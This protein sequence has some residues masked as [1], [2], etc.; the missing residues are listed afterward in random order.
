MTFSYS[1][2]EIN[3]ASKFIFE[4]INSKII[5]F[6]GDLGT[7]KTT[8]IKNLCLKLGSTENVSSPTFPILNIYEDKK[9]KIYHADLY[10][11]KNIKDLNELG[12]FEIINNDNWLFIEW[13]KKIIKVIDKPFSILNIEIDINNN[14][15]I[16]LRNNE[17]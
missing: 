1:L 3:K 10:R 8:L 9:I 2:S 16:Q 6:N 12:F 7:G 13:P 4:N 14:R 11:V 15:I 17:L 5:L